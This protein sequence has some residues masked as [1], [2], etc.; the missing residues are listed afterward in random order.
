MW[1]VVLITRWKGW[2]L[3]PRVILARGRGRS[4]TRGLEQS[5]TLRVMD[6]L[7]PCVRVDAPPGGWFPV[8]Q[9]LY[10]YIT[11]SNLPYADLFF[12]PRL[13]RI[14]IHVEWSWM[15]T[16]VP[17]GIQPTLASIIPALLTSSL[18]RMSV[19]RRRFPD[20]DLDAFQRLV[21]FCH[22]ALRTIIHGI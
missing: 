7:R 4:I 15:Y 3:E 16:G 2:K 1:Y 22:F 11:E 21:L 18:E 14:S 10:L 13:K 17:L 8:L 12:S 5:Q 9:D 6:A 20:D 19:L